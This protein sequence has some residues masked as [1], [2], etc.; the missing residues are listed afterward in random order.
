[1]EIE[2]VGAAIRDKGRILVAQR[3]ERM[4][5]PL[6][7]EFVGGKVE[8]GETHGEALAR[9]VYEELGIEIRILDYVASGSSQAEGKKINLH[10][11][12]AEIIKGIP[13]ITEHVRLCW[14]PASQ[15]DSL[16][17]PEADIPALKRLKEKYALEGGQK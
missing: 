16:D 17:W 4:S 6:K 12:E 11:Y 10:V 5:Q 3:S 15:L 2:V 1:M 7:W 14:V 9:E 8:K 13:K